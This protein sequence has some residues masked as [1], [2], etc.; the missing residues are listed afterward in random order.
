MMLIA[1]CEPSTAC[2]NTSTATLRFVRPST[3]AAAV[4]LI[5]VLMAIGSRERRARLPYGSDGKLGAGT[6]ARGRTTQG[7]IASSPEEHRAN[8]SLSARADASHR[9]H[10]AH[11]TARSPTSSPQRAAR[12]ALRRSRTSSPGKQLRIVT[13][14]GPTLSYRFA[15]NDRLTVAENGDGRAVEAGYGALD[16]RRR[17]AV[18]AS[19]ARHAARLS[20]RRR[21]QH[22]SRDRVRG[23]VQ[24]LHGQPRGAARDL[25]RLCGRAGQGSA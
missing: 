16:A 19:R 1:S 13:D 5:G 18:H 15:S 8:H 4:S 11:G 14:K 3:P 7:V 24:R 22:G 10:E 12:R 25:L 9:L 17:R 6:D 23:L 20:R 2:A 21:S